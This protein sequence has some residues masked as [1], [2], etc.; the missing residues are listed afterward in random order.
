MAGRDFGSR[1]SI[2]FGERA[3]FHRGGTP[4][5]ASALSE[6]F[7][8]AELREIRDRLVA[9][10]AAAENCACAFCSARGSN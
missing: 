6:G 1:Y 9:Q 5:G 4:L 10:G 8:V 2:T 3:I 7:S